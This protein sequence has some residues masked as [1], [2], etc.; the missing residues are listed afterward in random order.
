MPEPG[1]KIHTSTD[2]N[3]RPQCNTCEIPMWLLNIKPAELGLELRTYECSRCAGSQT[4]LVRS[5]DVA[6]NSNHEPA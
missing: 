6:A 2:A 5:N 1:V 4:L 3:N